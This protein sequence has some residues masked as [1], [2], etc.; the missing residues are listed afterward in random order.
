MERQRERRSKDEGL[1][2]GGKTVFVRVPMCA[3]AC[4]LLINVKS[5]SEPRGIRHIP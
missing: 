5:L 1:C 3:C 2:K 4:A